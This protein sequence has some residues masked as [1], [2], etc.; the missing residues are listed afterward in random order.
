MWAVIA[1]V[2]L[3]AGSDP[4]ALRQSLLESAVPAV[5]ALD[6][7]VD[8]TWTISEDRASGVGIYRFQSEQQA[9]ERASTIEVGSAAPGGATVAAVALLEVLVEI[10]G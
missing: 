6:G 9:R 5:R 3:P 2:A 8:A 10:S 7:L 4:E 1:T